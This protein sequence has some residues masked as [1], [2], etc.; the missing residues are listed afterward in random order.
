MRAWIG[1]SGLRLDSCNLSNTSSWILASC[2]LLLAS[3]SSFSSR[4][5]NAAFETIVE[6]ALPF[7]V[8]VVVVVIEDAVVVAVVLV[9]VVFVSLLLFDVPLLHGL[10]GLGDLAGLDS[11][12]ATT[13]SSICSN[14]LFFN[15]AVL[16]SW[17]FLGS[18]SFLLF[19]SD[20]GIT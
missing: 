11:S 6:T 12:S 16:G 4:T 7:V 15:G 19:L 1:E 3:S 18:A 17:I 8:A 2:C 13:V 14:R 10:N 20:I 5:F 9:V